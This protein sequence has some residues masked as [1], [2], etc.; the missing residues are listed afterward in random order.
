MRNV[1]T[2][3]GTDLKRPVVRWVR[4]TPFYTTTRPL[5]PSHAGSYRYAIESAAQTVL[6]EVGHP[7][8]R[9]HG[10]NGVARLLAATPREARLIPVSRTIT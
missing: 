4:I 10:L 7:R 1:C 3:P 9:G 6:I 2:E 8:P 5:F